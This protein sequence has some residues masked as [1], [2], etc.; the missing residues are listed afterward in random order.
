MA[1]KEVKVDDFA[2]SM[3]A[4]MGIEVTSKIAASYNR[5]KILKDRLTPGRLSPEGFAFVV[6]LS[7]IE[8]EAEAKAE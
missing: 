5:M 4:A 3:F 6:T 2:A 1:E 7:E 8:G